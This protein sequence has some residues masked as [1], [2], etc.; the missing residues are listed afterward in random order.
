MHLNTLVR[1]S[2]YMIYQYICIDIKISLILDIE[3]CCITNIDLTESSFANY[4]NTAV[5][6][7]LQ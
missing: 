5:T 3:Y 4:S 6:K 2:R 1:L 7:G